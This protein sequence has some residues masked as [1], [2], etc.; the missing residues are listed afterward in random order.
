MR[1][2]LII[3]GIIVLLVSV[4]LSGCNKQTNNNSGGD[5]EETTVDNI[6]NHVNNYIGKTVAIRGCCYGY[7]VSMPYAI[8]DTDQGIMYAIN[9][10]DFKD[11]TIHDGHEYEYKF[12]GIIREGDV[13]DSDYISCEYYIEVIKIE[14]I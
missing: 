9:T 13:P 1:K 7:N 6:K 5:V 2:Q 8:H 4:G 11:S 14:S 3:I 12:I 10:D